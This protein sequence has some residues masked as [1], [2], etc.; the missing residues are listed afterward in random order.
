MT[1]KNIEKIIK[2]LRGSI[3]GLAEG[4]GIKLEIEGYMPLSISWAGEDEAL[5]ADLVAALA[6]AVY[7][8][9][10]LIERGEL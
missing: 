1:M 5:G 9:H 6:L 8:F 4:K 7:L 3:E 10:W 2:M